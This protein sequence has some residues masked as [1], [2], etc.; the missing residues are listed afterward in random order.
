[1]VGAKGRPG[2]RPRLP[3]DAENLK[4]LFSVKREGAAD[5]WLPLLGL[6]QGTRLEEA[7]QLR[8]EDV[9]I[10]DGI[11][12]L[13]IHGCDGRKVKTATS[14]RRVPLH[15][16]I[17]RLGFLNHVEAQ[18]TAGQ[19]RVFS[20]LSQSTHGEFSAAWSKSFGRFLRNVVKITDRRLVYHSLRHTFAS[21]CREVMPGT[22]ASPGRLV[23]G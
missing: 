20:E 16:E 14:E 1:M 11:H 23:F 6:Y 18:R 2:D 12:Y 21:A 3:F 7:A 8:C 15:P 17:I 10:E 19:E 5:Y 4:K 13:D 9:K 22:S